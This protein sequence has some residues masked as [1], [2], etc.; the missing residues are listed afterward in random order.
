MADTLLL[1]ME[2]ILDHLSQHPPDP[3]STLVLAGAEASSHDHS[4]R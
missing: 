4:G 1:E 2:S 3:S